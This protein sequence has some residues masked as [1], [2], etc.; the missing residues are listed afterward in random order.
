VPVVESVEQV[1]SLWA[2]L[3]YP[4]GNR[5]VG[6][7]VS[8]AGRFGNLCDYLKSAHEQIC[9]I[10]QL[11]TQAGIEALDDM[12]AGDGIDGFFIGLSGLS[13]DMGIWMI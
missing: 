4:N 8:Q 11:E 2:A 13:A 10:A 6:S 1:R 12:L 7:T 3:R 5:G 9:L